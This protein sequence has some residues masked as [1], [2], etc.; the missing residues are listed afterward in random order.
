ML[1]LLYLK[2][3]TIALVFAALVSMMAIG[4]GL[5]EISMSYFF[6]SFFVSY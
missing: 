5:P 1:F 3:I 4:G 2:R 6:V